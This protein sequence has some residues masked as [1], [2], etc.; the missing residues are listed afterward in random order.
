MSRK[1]ITTRTSTSYAAPPLSS[2]IAETHT[3]SPM[4][5]ATSRASIS[6]GVL[7]RA[8]ASTSRIPKREARLQNGSS[9]SAASSADMLAQAGTRSSFGAAALSTR[10]MNM[11]R[12]PCS[13]QT[14]SAVNRICERTSS[15]LPARRG[16]GC[17]QYSLRQ[18]ESSSSGAAAFLLAAVRRADFNSSVFMPCSFHSSFLSA[19]SAARSRDCTVRSGTSSTSDTSRSLSP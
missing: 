1:G 10:Q 4:P 13:A 12:A 9:V 16:R 18:R 15:R 3:A 14:G 6:L 11:S 7:K 2:A 17:E 5:T 8:A 19:L